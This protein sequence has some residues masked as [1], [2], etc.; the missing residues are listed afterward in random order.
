MLNAAMNFQKFVNIGIN[1]LLTQKFY[2]RCTQAKDYILKSSIFDT[3]YIGVF[4]SLNGVPDFYAC[5]NPT[6]M[7]EY[8]KKELWFVDPIVKESLLVPEHSKETLLSWT[9]SMSDSD[10]LEYRNAFIGH[11]KGFSKV[12]KHELSAEEEVIVIGIG[13]Y[14]E[15]LS[16]DKPLNLNAIFREAENKIH[17]FVNVTA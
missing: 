4:R 7:E 11:V 5:S 15:H 13:L 1:M 17:E 6:W 16:P 3:I 10:F 8:L 14:P 2:D 9:M 12:L